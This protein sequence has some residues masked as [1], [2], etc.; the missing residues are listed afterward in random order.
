MS[1]IKYRADV[2]GLRAVAVL[3]VLFFHAGYSGFD[4]GFVG[5]DV[6]FVISGFLITSLIL[7]E[8][9]NKCFSIIQFY[10]RRFRR[11]L[12]AMFVTTV[13]TAIIAWFILLPP[14]FVSFGKSAAALAG[15]SSN[16]YF[17][18]QTSGYFGEAAEL[19]P[20]LHTWSLAVEEQFYIFFPLILVLFFKFFPRHLGRLILILTIVSL[21]LRI[22]SENYPETAFY[23]LHTRGW[24]LMLG[25]LLSVGKR[26]T[27]TARHS[28]HLLQEIAGIGGMVAIFA[29][30]ILYDVE[31][32]VT[33]L[34]LSNT[35]TAQF[36]AS[37]GAFFVIW[38]NTAGGGRTTL[39]GKLLSLKPCVAVGLISYSLYL[40][41]WPALVF[42]KYLTAD[43]KLGLSTATLMLLLSVAGAILT[44]L[45]VEQPFRRRQI[46]TERQPLFI[47]SFAQLLILAV[48]GAGIAY[49]AKGAPSRFPDSAIAYLNTSENIIH[50][51][52]FELSEGKIGKRQIQG[53]GKSSNG[54]PDFLLW[55][56]SHADML[57]PVLDELA[58]AYGL[59]GWYTAYASNPPLLGTYVYKKN[60]RSDVRKEFNDAMFR[61]V[62]EKQIKTVILSAFWA[63]YSTDREDGGY[64]LSRNTAERNH[65]FEESLVD[66]INFF[67][68]NGVDLWIIKDVPSY[69]YNVSH[70]LAKNA[71]YGNINK[72]SQ[73]LTEH[74][75]RM[76]LMNRLLKE[77]R[78]DGLY[79]PDPAE[80]LCKSGACITRLEG[81]S[82]YID[83]NHLSRPGV[84]L[85]RDLLTPLF[86]G[87]L[88]KK[89]K[90]YRQNS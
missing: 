54:V 37:T 60:K 42:A 44:Y 58:K 15:F 25:A 56:D 13:L 89:N 87:A 78:H 22:W 36:L 82:L 63:K 20:L 67:R 77:A 18:K 8:L 64:I 52:G 11:I 29:A 47:A 17:W 62:I 38:G 4:G 68:D 69:S 74:N 88:D 43:E 30:V 24:E 65:I 55:G 57:V 40:W 71:I 53:I 75:Q 81:K 73:P 34:P 46:F 66:T 84:M 39:T 70:A 41:H 49:G 51:P 76:E 9:D 83:G 2:D 12:P 61:L 21:S 90:T 33:L 50:N 45:F 14:D 28:S 59:T 5:V 32:I 23:M 27:A 19:M 3:V 10:E 7:K 48:I 6:F 1:D 16:V 85:L 72:V 80:V 31:A 35:L 86:L 79:F 26:T